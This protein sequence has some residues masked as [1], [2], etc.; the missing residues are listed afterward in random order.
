MKSKENSWV[1]NLLGWGQRRQSTTAETLYAATVEVARDP[2]LFTTY[3][4]NDDVD[5]R[6]DALALV[7]ALV[8]RRLKDCGD[9]GKELSQQLFDSMFADMDLSLR[10][11][12]AGDLGVAKR[13]RVMAEGFMGRLDAYAAALDADDD[14]ALASALTRNL[15]RGDDKIDPA[16][17]GLV[18]HVKS[19]ATRFEAV[20]ETELLAGKLGN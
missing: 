10:E 19:L 6:F 15:L 3:G 13:V 17:N 14:A 11:M 20:P 18:G 12:G 2:A 5:G 7:V 1:K 8:M 16:G 9:E 4:V